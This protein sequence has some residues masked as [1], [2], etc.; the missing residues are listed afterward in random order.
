MLHFK[1]IHAERE[2]ER[3]REITWSVSSELLS[4]SP[5]E[6]FLIITN[7][8]SSFWYVSIK[9][10]IEY[11]HCVVSYNDRVC[12]GLE[13]DEDGILLDILSSVFTSFSA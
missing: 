12:A 1:R 13:T 10:A 7:R 9:F 5:R 2:R 3:E 11:S 4:V 6:P 8:G